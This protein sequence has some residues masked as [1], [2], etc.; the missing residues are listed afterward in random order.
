M[1]LRDGSEGSTLRALAL[2]GM[3]Y[4]REHQAAEQDLATGYDELAAARADDSVTGLRGNMAR[5]AGARAVAVRMTSTRKPQLPTVDQALL[6][7]L[8]IELPRVH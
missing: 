2:L 7:V 4:V 3:A 8:G 6:R 5:R 1:P